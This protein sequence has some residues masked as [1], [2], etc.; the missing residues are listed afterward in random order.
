MPAAKTF[1]WTHA[2]FLRLLPLLILGILCAWYW[3]PALST[4]ALA[5]SFAL[6]GTLGYPFLSKGLK[7]RLRAAAGGCL[8]LLL[9]ALGAWLV[10]QEN[11]R[12][13]AH[14]FG[15]TYQQGD[16]LIA[17]LDEMPVQK[18][19]SL[20]A[21]ARITHL[22]QNG[23]MI[24]ATGHIIL[25]F[26]KDS[27]AGQLVYGN[28]ILLKKPLQ[29]IQNSGNPGAFDYQRYC[30]FGGI[31]HQ[32]FLN[33]T[34][35]RTLPGHEGK[36]LQETLIRSRETIVAILQQHIRTPRE[37]GLAEALLIGFKDDLD[38][39]LVQAYSNTGVVHVIAISGLH[40]GLIYGLLVV[41]AK[42]LRRRGRVARFLFIAGGL[43]AFTLVAGAQP[44]VV[45]SAVMFT[46]MALGDLIGRKTSPL[47][48]LAFSA[49]GLL[50]FNPFWLWDLGF[51]LSYTAVAGIL[52][53]YKPFYHLLYFPNK[54]I[55]ALW[56]LV[57][58]T[59]TAQ[60]L[61]LPISLF[62]FHQ[63]PVLFLITNLLAVPLSSG[64]LY[65][66]MALCIFHPI[67]PL[68]T[69]IGWLT[70]VLICFLNDYIMRLSTLPFALWDGFS[71]SVLQVVLLYAAIGSAGA[72]LLA[73]NKA[74]LRYALCLLL[75]FAGLRT[76]SLWEAAQLNR[77]VVYHVPRHRAADLISGR[78][79]FFRGDTA[80]LHD[81]FE[82]AFHLRPARILFRAGAVQPLEG[83]AFNFGGK[84]V[85]FYDSATRF[86]QMHC[87]VLVVSGKAEV[88]HRPPGLQPTQLVLDATV[89]QYR[90]QQWQRLSDSLGWPLHDVRTAGAFVM[91]W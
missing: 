73:K 84:T 22:V 76:Y 62:H 49:A 11:I 30:L 59:L 77:L 60:I 51:Q 13:H 45:R 50:C 63:F 61:T 83:K 68:A 16:G 34:E 55:D 15:Q 69:A 6:L 10:H 57:A 52:I 20:K 39:G 8:L 19:R 88:P 72:W 9:W 78:Q 71:F 26:Q 5:G 12:N 64:I 25:Y 35:Y 85:L 23:R 38:K 89:P 70:E 41:V 42:V 65:L 21:I 67:T 2:P 54:A 47:N 36:W 56:Q 79:V 53:F 48:T 28:R 1:W 44:S 91:Q 27:S 40:L 81:G 66:E 87:A 43:W 31:T 90:V 46:C 7:Y 14:W 80:L 74:A 29:P 17:A 82:R 4:I 3:Q 24:R 75:L 37:R 18:P 32:V 86:P 33:E 58:L